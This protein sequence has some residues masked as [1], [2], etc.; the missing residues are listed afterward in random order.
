MQQFKYSIRHIPG[1]ENVADALS[2][3]PVDSVPDA[4][5]KQTEEYERSIVA[6]AIPA[7]L[8]PHLVERESEGD[9]TLQLVCHAIT[10][11][12]WSKLQ[13]TTYKAIRDE[14]WIIGQ[15]VMRGNKVVMPEKLWKQTIQLAHLD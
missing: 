14:L 12:D 15:L 8:S 1:K 5:I 6:D 9:P 13:G 7:A 11:G 2:K 4:A 3:L 10:S